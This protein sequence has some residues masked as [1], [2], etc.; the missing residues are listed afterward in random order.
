MRPSVVASALI[1][2]LAGLMFTAAATASR[3]TD[4]RAERVT[5]L[6][7]LVR[8]ES[9]RT[10][11]LEESVAEKQRAVDDLV[12]GRTAFAERRPPVFRGE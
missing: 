7:D 3:G 5:Q 4:L 10:A 8:Q 1:F 6:R 12:E 11:Q 9:T 2:A